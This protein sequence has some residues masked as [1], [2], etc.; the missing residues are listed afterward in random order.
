MRFHN[1][2]FTSGQEPSGEA[3][4]TL[5][6]VVVGETRVGKSC[7]LR[8]LVSEEFS[9]ETINTIGTSYSTVVVP[10]PSGTVQIQLWD[11]AGQEQYRSLSLMYCRKAQVV[12]FVYDIGRRDTF[13]KLL[14]WVGAVADNTQGNVH[15]ILVASKCDLGQRAVSRDEAREFAGEI[16][17]FAY[18][19][20]SAKTGSGV[21]ELLR[22]IAQVDPEQSP[23]VL[24]AAATDKSGCC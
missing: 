20:T 6:V 11:T 9:D 22:A 2:D 4:K 21:T 8:R 19:E 5:R 18:L 17:A 23:T 24:S 14:H 13:R 10:R 12:L 16:E 3:M 7:L 15:K 1:R